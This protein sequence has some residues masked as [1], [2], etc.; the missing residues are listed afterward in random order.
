VVN[1]YGL[2]PNW[3]VNFSDNDFWEKTTLQG[4]PNLTQKIAG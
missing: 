2:N 4:I 1:H 3:D